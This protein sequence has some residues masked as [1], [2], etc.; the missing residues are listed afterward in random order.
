[1]IVYLATNKVNG[2]QYVGQTIRPLLERWKDHCR[3]VDNNYFH[4]AI[5]KY[6]AENFSLEIID[7]AETLEELDRKEMYWIEELGT[8]YPNGYNLK[9]GGNVS[10]RGRFGAMNPKSRLIYQFRLDGGIENA[11]YGVG[12]AERG[13]GIY[14][15]AI[16]RSLKKLGNVAGGCV[17]L[18][19]SDFLENMQLPAEAIDIYN[20]KRKKKVVCVETGE[21]FDSMKEAAE[22]YGLFYNSI[23]A[24][25]KGRLKTTG[26][27]H[28][29][30]YDGRR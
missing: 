24:C 26:G 1:M 29:K 6:G 22:K 18:Y 25:C 27:Y 15:S 13:T 8:L 17:W 11:Y 10:M 4:N 3:V 7:Q 20:G 19:A 5:R 30:Y 28:W 12:E 14:N 16:C 2:K 23:S 9:E 21:C